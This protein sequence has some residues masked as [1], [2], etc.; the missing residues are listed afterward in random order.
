MLAGSFGINFDH[1]RP[2]SLSLERQCL[3]EL[4]PSRI[5]NA[6]IQSRLSRLP[7]R[8]K[9][10]R[11]I[12]FRVA[13]SGHVFHSQ[14]FNKDHLRLPQDF[15]C[16][17]TVKLFAL[18]CHLLMQPSNLAIEQLPGFASFFGSS[19]FLLPFG[20]LFFSL[21]AMLRNRFKFP[22]RIRQEFFQSQINPNT[23]I[24]SWLNRIGELWNHLVIQTQ[25]DIPS[26]HFAGDRGRFDGE[27]QLAR[28]GAKPP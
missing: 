26:I 6:L 9:L 24:P 2:I 11:L 4:T 27:P 20:K 28:D 17:F 3:N 14:I 1:L 23:V 25:R 22:W 8:E 10:T 12:L 21:A 5:S 19:N 7:I 18:P 16:R 13:A 15:L